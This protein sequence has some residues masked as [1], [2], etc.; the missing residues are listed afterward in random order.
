MAANPQWQTIPAVRNHRVFY[1]P[2]GIFIF[3]RPTAESAVLYPLWLAIKAYPERFKD[4]KLKDE[5]RRFYK[6]ICGWSL[7][8]EQVANIIS[9]AYENRMKMTGR[10]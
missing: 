9:G 2:A 10:Y 1:E 3:N 8:D 4:I 7:S 6:E 5:V